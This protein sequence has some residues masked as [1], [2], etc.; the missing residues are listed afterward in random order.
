MAA[1]RSHQEFRRRMA[2]I[3]TV[4]CPHCLAPLPCG[5]DEDQESR[6]AHYAVC[7]G[8]PQPVEAIATPMIIGDINYAAMTEEQLKSLRLSM[9]LRLMTFDNPR[10]M[11]GINALLK[12]AYQQMFDAAEA[13]LSRRK[14]DK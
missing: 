11:D 5:R 9:K 8:K 14:G 10:R 7:P 13:E 1:M 4:Q 3:T 12:P 2:A 6:M